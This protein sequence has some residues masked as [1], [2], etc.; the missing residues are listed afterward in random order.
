MID[1][2]RLF[3]A[4]PPPPH[5]PD[6]WPTL[7]QV[8]DALRAIRPDAHVTVVA[9]AIIAVPRQVKSQVDAYA[10]SVLAPE[11]SGD[12]KA[13]PASGGVFARAR[14]RLTAH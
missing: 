4:S 1:D 10:R 2:A 11:W 13:A 3:I 12:G 8:F 7:L 14:R 6:Q 5:H 9:D